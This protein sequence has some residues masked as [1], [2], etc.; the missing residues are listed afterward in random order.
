MS[1]L[2]S[3]LRRL[4]TQLCCRFVNVLLSRLAYAVYWLGSQ[5]PFISLIFFYE[6]WGTEIQ[7]LYFFFQRE[8]YW[9]Q[10]LKT[11]SGNPEIQQ[12]GFQLLELFLSRLDFM[13]RYVLSF[14]YGA[15][16][17]YRHLNQT[18]GLISNVLHVPCS[19]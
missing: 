13:L 9:S 11:N 18:Q 17:A 15:L 7:S 6:E 19:C 12:I 3:G 16:I 10:R 5:L 8:R 4:L 1:A 2:C 14:V